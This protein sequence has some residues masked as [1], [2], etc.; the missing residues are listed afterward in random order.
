MFPIDPRAS[1]W[2]NKLWLVSYDVERFV[3]HGWAGLNMEYKVQVWPRFKA[4]VL[5]GYLHSPLYCTSGCLW[6]LLDFLHHWLPGVG[7]GHRHWETY[8]TGKRRIRT[9][10]HGYGVKT[11]MIWE[12]VSVCF[13][14]FSQS[15]SW[16]IVP[17]LSTITDVT[18]ECV[19]WSMKGT[20][21]EVCREM[22]KASGRVK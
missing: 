7:H 12:W 5:A 21:S 13:S 20:E 10:L 15:S 19:A 18:G 8:F 4:D 16:W 1:C 11:F 6:K 22:I 3:V 17:V 2:V 14:F 9:G